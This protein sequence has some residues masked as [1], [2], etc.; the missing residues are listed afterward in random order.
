MLLYLLPT[1]LP[2]IT[3]QP[4]NVYAQ[5]N[6]SVTLNC[7]AIGGN[8]INYTWIRNGTVVQNSSNY[9]SLT[10]ESVE[11][12]DEG[13]YQCEAM[14]ERGEVALSEQAEII[15]YGKHS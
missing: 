9:G 11:K 5:H 6:A 14:N 3:V 1:V 15:I 2:S 8:I 10:I 4:E 7:E 13:A 12:S